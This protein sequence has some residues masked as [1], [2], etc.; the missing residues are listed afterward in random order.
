MTKLQ[1]VSKVVF[2]SFL[3]FLLFAFI[4]TIFKNFSS[5]PPSN[6]SQ[7]QLYTNK[8]TRT[9][10]KQ[11]CVLS[12]S[13]FQEPD[14]PT[15]NENPKESNINKTNL[16]ASN[17]AGSS[18]VQNHNWT[19]NDYKSDTS[20]LLRNYSSKFD[21]E[22]LTLKEVLDALVNYNAPTPC[23]MWQQNDYLC[24]KRNLKSFSEV[25]HYVINA[26]LLPCRKKLLKDKSTSSL[27]FK[28]IILCY[29]KGH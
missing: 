7:K 12:K 26:K 21:T 29:E 8:S 9:A 5:N 14:K 16:P 25:G 27:G 20:L 18:K 15:L 13:F 17:A 10:S 1:F 3:V 24:N 4:Q 22:A 6:A 28:S 23:Q 2:R 11:F 19:E